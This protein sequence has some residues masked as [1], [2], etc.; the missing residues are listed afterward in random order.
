MLILGTGMKLLQK[1]KETTCP[2]FTHAQH[3]SNGLHHRSDLETT[4]MVTMIGIAG[5]D[6]GIA[7]VTFTGMPG[8]DAGITGHDGPEYALGAAASTR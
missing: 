7:S 2:Q 3:R 8:H 1:S 5:H 6:T 4:M